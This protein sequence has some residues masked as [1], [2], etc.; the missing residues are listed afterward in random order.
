MKRKQRQQVV[1]AVNSR[2]MAAAE[3]RVARKE[4]K[5][6]E[7]QKIAE[8]LIKKPVSVPLIG[9]ETL[10]QAILEK[11]PRLLDHGDYRSALTKVGRRPGRWIRPLE[12]WQPKGRARDTLFYSLMEHLFAK[13]KTPLFVWNAFFTPDYNLLNDCGAIPLVK[14]A[15]DIAGGESAYKVLNNLVPFTRRMAHDIMQITG[16]VGFIEAIRTVQV[17]SV[18]G[19]KRLLKAYM[20]AEGDTLRR[21]EDETFW[22]TVIQWFANSPMLDPNQV[23]PLCDY[24]RRR[25]AEDNTFSMK[26]RTPAALMRSMNEWHRDLTR[27]KV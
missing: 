7:E 16:H 22:A 6:K 27:V 19:D 9:C 11:A 14:A 4:L 1:E 24:I 23:G 21:I 15:V 18:G 8:A 13:Y 12:D 5:D 2:K 26:G 3:N 17:K 20:D 10:A 25:R